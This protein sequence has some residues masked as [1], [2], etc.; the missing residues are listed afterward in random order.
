MNTIKIAVVDD[1]PVVRDGIRYLVSLYEDIDLII[2]AGSGK[3]LIEKLEKVRPN[4]ILLDIKLPDIDG[5]ELTKFILSKNPQ[6]KII[7]LSF[8]DEEWRIAQSIENGAHAYLVKESMGDDVV[9]AIREV[10]EHG[11]YYTKGAINAMR[12]GLQKKGKVKKPIAGGFINIEL[13]DHQL[14]ILKLICQGFTSSEIAEKLYLSAKTITSHRSK[15]LTK[16]GAI[17]T[18]EMVAYAVG[19]GLID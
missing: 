9:K 19:N 16:F 10:F 6:I 8:H 14:K 18:V 15:L 2:E 1:H 12:K 11:F 4:V 7:I 3:D 17:N 13:T 5:L